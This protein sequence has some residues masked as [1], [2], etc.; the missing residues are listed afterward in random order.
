MRAD[1]EQPRLNGCIWQ[2]AAYRTLMAF[3]WG[4]LAGWPRMAAELPV[5][6][7][8]RGK[9]VEVAFA[10]GQTHKPTFRAALAIPGFGRSFS[11]I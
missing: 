1:L 4:A 9:F 7:G 6:P 2:H 11:I 8:Q 10:S 3:H 5:M